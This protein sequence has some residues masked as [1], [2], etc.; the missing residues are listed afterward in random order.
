[1]RKVETIRWLHLSDLHIFYS[2]EWEIMKRSYEDL[3]KVFSP[4]FIV[5]TGDFCHKKHNTNYDDALKFLC[6]ISKIFEVKR[7]HFFFV[8]GNHDATTFE[9]RT[10]K[11][12]SINSKINRQP[13]VCTQHIPQLLSAF[14]DYDAFVQK[15]YGH[16]ESRTHPR[17]KNP[18]T[19]SYTTWKKK[20]NIVL[21]NT[22]LLSNGDSENKNTIVDIDGLNRISKEMKKRRNTKPTLVL[23]HHS[24]KSLYPNI[25]KQLYRFFPLINARAYLCGD[26]HKLKRN[27]IQKFN[28][29]KETV[30][31]VCG[32]SAVEPDDTYSDVCVIG[33]EW[34]GSKANVYVFKWI[35]AKA[36]PSE[37]MDPSE[38][39]E[40]SYVFKKTDM[41]VHDIVQPFSFR[42]VEE[43]EPIFEVSNQMEESW[44]QL[45]SAFEGVDHIVNSR[46]RDHQ[47]LNKSGEHESFCTEKIIKSLMGIGIPFPAVS[48]IT[49][50]AIYGLLRLSPSNSPTWELD[51]K[52]I[53]LKVLDAIKDYRN[54]HWT[55]ESEHWCTKYI[56][57]YGHNN[58]TV[59]LCNIP[60]ALH[61]ESYTGDATYRLIKEILIPDLF[62][63]ICPSFDI[64]SLSSANRSRLAKEFFAFINECDIYEVDYHTLKEMLKEIVTKPPHPW[65][66]SD[67]QRQETISYDQAAVKANLKKIETCEKLHEKVPYITFIE[68]LHHSSSMILANYSNYLGCADLDSYRILL[69]HIKRLTT[70]RVES[71]TRSEF[72]AKQLLA[73]KTAFRSQK[74]LVLDYRDRLESLDP[75]IGKNVGSKDYI[76]KIKEFAQQ[77][78]S[79][80]EGFHN[81]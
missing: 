27:L 25:R 34:A 81:Q 28:A 45:L 68:L 1:M 48:E 51:T 36:V 64:S 53:R 63:A 75:H 4:D 12:D 5:V 62:N 77:S 39:T 6:E 74:N 24:T 50:Q 78:L 2:V 23:A 42:M 46:L 67:E 65:I 9:G 29:D 35:G 52:T 16:I 3:A 10:E 73:L 26:A 54:P 70:S 19:V 58:R 7:D 69:S 59:Q 13:N 40:P 22:A 72:E 56:R 30:E 11:I 8:P 20:L 32:K 44:K 31:I 66:I 57:K 37:D 60:S 71:D 21:L 17:F 79:L 55:L 15:F 76:S 33:Y 38:D 61:R 43:S 47:I 14:S 80:A 41:W 18:S 49:Q